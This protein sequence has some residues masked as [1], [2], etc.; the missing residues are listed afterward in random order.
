[1]GVIV[2]PDEPGSPQPTPSLVLLAQVA[3]YLRER[4]PPTAT[5]WV[6]GL[7]WITVAVTATV[8]VVSVPDADAAGDR[9][10]TA[11][12]GYLHPLTGG[13]A[14]QGWAF[15]QWPHESVLSAVLAAVDGVD[16]VRSLDV[17]YQPQTDAAQADQI[18][19]ILTR[20][21]NQPSDAPQRE[22]G[23]R[24]WIDRALVYSGRHD[25]SVMLG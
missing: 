9:A 21:L 3:D 4:C 15:G 22:Q 24:D 12:A 17:D 23:Q 6:A 8:V 2:V 11:L 18:R 13:P 7:E 14:G 19:V 5:L 25:I 20:P 10:T 16:H 1:M